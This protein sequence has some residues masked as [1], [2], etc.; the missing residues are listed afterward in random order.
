MK[1]K[2]ITVKGYLLLIDITV[3]GIL[4]VLPVHDPK[5][6]SVANEDQHCW[7]DEGDDEKRSLRRAAVVIRHY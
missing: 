1:R 2:K 4:N 5:Y 7:N 3:Q 6:S